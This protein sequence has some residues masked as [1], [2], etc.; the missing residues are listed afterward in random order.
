M[1]DPVF[2]LDFLR[3]ASF[4]MIPITLA[5]IGEI[6]TEKAGVV[7]IGLEG[8]MLLSAFV[9]AV[10]AEATGSPWLGLLAGLATGTL[11]GLLHGIISAYLKGDQIISGVGINIL[12]LGFVPFGI[13]VVWNVAGYHPVPPEVQVP[14]LPLL[15][16]SPL[17]PITIAIAIATHLLLY[18][19]RLGMAI[20]AVG[21]NPEAADTVGIRVERVQL[22]ATAYGASLAGLGGAFL[23]IDWLSEI[24][25]EISAGRGFIALALVNFANWNTI[26]ALG[27][28][29]LFGALWTIAEWF[30]TMAEIKA[31]IPVTL[32]NTIPY[33]ATLAVTAGFIGRSR[34]PAWI[35]RP[36]K[37]E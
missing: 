24:T 12:A 14:R 26:L 8:I 29:L 25:K 6:V 27:G 4:A 5:A 37:R 36:Y 21:E 10:A 30:K 28:G 34:P 31:V 7:N 15:G 19:T 35:G 9:A 3:A 22:L 17:V 23:S 16:I 2:I 11:I 1:A 13:I 33:I 32:I 18:R 20:R